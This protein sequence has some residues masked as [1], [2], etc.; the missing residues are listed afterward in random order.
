MCYD[1]FGV[2]YGNPDFVKNA[3]AYGANGYPTLLVERKWVGNNLSP[4]FLYGLQTGQ[5]MA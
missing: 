1:D 5:F 3:E 4:P 2:S